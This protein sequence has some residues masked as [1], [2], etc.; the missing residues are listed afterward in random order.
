MGEKGS[1]RERAERFLLSLSRPCANGF[2]ISPRPFAFAAFFVY[3]RLAL[4]V[5]VSLFFS[6]R[7]CDLRHPPAILRF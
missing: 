6:S 7:V 5:N 1:E 3:E 2:H 4:P